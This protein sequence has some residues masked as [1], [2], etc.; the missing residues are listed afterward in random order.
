MMRL[1]I[2]F[3]ETKRLGDLLQ[4]V[5]DFNR[6]QFFLTESIISISMAL[7]CICVYL[8]VIGQLNN[9]LNQIVSFI[10][11]YQDTKISVER[12]SEI[13][14]AKDESSKNIKNGFEVPDSAE[15]SFRNVTFQYNGH[16]SRKILSNVS[17][18]IPPNKVTAIVRGSGNGK[19]TI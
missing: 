11:S 14:N 15:I 9:P 16:R 7:I 3:F 1:P 10:Q 6:I 19:T 13:R 5:E 2:S 8:F 12:F 18:S 17:F 4:R